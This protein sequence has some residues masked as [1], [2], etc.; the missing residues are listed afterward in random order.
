VT[1]ESGQRAV[2]RRDNLFALVAGLLTGIAG[3]FFGVGGGIML[4]PLLTARFRLSQHQAHGTSLAVIGTTALV[5]LVV[6]AMHSN[7]A[8]TTAAVMGAASLITARYGARL[9]VRTSPTSLAKAFAVF[10]M[11][12]ALRLLWK[13]P[14]ATNAG[15]QHGPERIALD[16]S[17]GLAV[18]LLSGYMGIGGGILIVP[19]LALL[20]GM[21][22]Q[23]AQGTSL[24]V[25]LMVA[26]AG[27]YEHT[28]HGNVVWGLVPSLALGAAIGGPLA[29]WLAQALDHAFL[30]RAFAIFMLVNAAHTWVRARRTPGAA[31]PGKT[32]GP[33][34]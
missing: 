14:E 34:S 18:G 4:V 3:G 30:A 32:E 33:S 6:Y 5:S 16:L 10:V 17:L 27:A 29:S 26:P 9:A 23:L 7:V 25:I 8:W 11:V 13:T 31:E 28:R 19:A 21:P 22:Q 12:V 1:A 24:A 2:T 20:V 15:F